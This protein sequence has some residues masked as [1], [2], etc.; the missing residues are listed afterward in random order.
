[1]YYSMCVYNLSDCCSCCKRL[2]SL[3]RGTPVSKETIRWKRSFGLYTIV[4]LAL[5]SMVLVANALPPVIRV[6]AIFTED[7]REGSVESAFKYAIYRI[8]KEK[9]LLPNTQLVY[10]IEYVPRD[11]S[12]RTT[13]KVCRQLEAGVQAIFGPSDPSLASH[14]QSICEAF[15]IPHIEARIDLEVSVKEFSINLYPSQN[16]MNLAYRDLMM[17]LNWTKVA[18]IYE[19]DYG[20]FKQQDLIHSS[21]EMRTEMYIRQANPETYR[22]VLRAIRQKEIYKIIVDTNPTNI[23]KFFRSIL[24]LQMNDHRYHYMFTTFDLETYDLEDF[25]YNSVN[26]TAFRLVDVGSKRYQDIIDQMQKLQHSGLDLINGVPYI[27]TE[28]ALMFDSVYAFAHGLKQLDSSHTLTFKNLSCNSDRVWSDGLSLYNYINSAAVDGLTGKVNFIEGR[29][30]KFKIDILKLKQ[31]VIQKVG[32]WQPD[33]GVNISDPT[34]FYDSNIAN[35]TLIVMTREERPYVMVKEDANITGNARFEGFCID[36]LKAIAQQVGFQYKIELVPDNM[37]GVYIPETNSWNGIVQEL[38]ERRADLA[39]ASMT[40]NYARESVIDFTK[41]FMNLGIGILFKISDRAQTKFFSFMNP[42]AIEIWFYIAF[43]YILVSMCIWIVARLSPMEWVRSKP[44]CTMACDHMLR[45]IRKAN[46][47]YDHFELKFIENPTNNGTHKNDDNNDA[48]DVIDVDLGD[49]SDSDDTLELETV[50]NSFTLKNSFWFAIG[51]LMQQGADLYPRATSTRIV[52]GCWFFFCLIIISSY[53]AN[54][55]A[56]LTVE[57]MI[58]PI[59]SAADLADQTEIQYGTLEGGSTMTFFRDSKIGIYQ[60]MWRYMENRKTSVFVKTYEDGIKRVMEGNYAFLME[61]T[62]LDYAV[63]RDC[64]LTQI[65]GLLDSK[66]YG[67]ATPKGSPWRDKISLAILELQEKGIIQILYD[68]WWKNTGDVCNRDDKSKESKANAL[69]VENIGG[70][71][72]V[73]LCGLALAVVVAIFE[74]CWNSKKNLHTDNQSLCSEMAEE[75]RFAMHCQGSKSK[76][77]PALKR[78][79]LKCAPGS[80]YVPTNVTMPNL[81]VH[82]NYFN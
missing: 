34:A 31:E 4:H 41:P 25:R 50:Q 16:I 29:R 78:D 45:K 40:I 38:M 35:I 54:L 2:R 37:Y 82:Y 59:E 64:N 39:V 70:V 62:M 15:D 67:I 17:Y 3:K 33:V 44:A 7:E 80:T 77:R 24:Q 8:N 53:T 60:K 11:D 52:G 1:M 68:K 23:K 66:G 6:G 49:N 13:K 32:F 27:Q 76:Q 9:I 61:S 22:Q 18:I 71:F 5:F 20:L 81:G 65:G 14:V 74:F 19:E 63:Q 58:T 57:R 73:L 36:L 28:S 56:F 69:G 51:A 55:A 10:D 75:L 48:N 46:N 26:I 79:C 72:V 42:L 43:G 21:A 12:F 47:A 30:N